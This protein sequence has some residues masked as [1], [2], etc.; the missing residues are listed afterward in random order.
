MKCAIPRF[1]SPTPP[2]NLSPIPLD[3]DFEATPFTVMNSSTMI[4][5]L[6][7]LHLRI[8]IALAR[9]LPFP[10][11]LPTFLPLTAIPFR[12]PFIEDKKRRREIKGASETE[13]TTTTTI[14]SGP[15]RGGPTGHG[16]HQGREGGS[17]SD[18][19][20]FYGLSLRLF[21]THLFLI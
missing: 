16:R 1:L 20:C 8:I 19:C 15:T 11:P 6:L 13:T 21:S 2:A 7:L 9:S 17:R 12:L 5:F 14:C 3:L 10:S 18:S 4:A